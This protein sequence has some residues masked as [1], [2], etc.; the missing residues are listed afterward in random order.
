MNRAAAL[1]KDQSPPMAAE[2]PERAS[3]Q[4]VEGVM[5]PG[6]EQTGWYA[7]EDD[8]EDLWDNVPL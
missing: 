8:D 5:A 6:H 4:L 7:S 2:Q 3:L 1:S